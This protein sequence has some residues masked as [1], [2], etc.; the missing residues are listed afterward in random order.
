[1]GGLVPHR[2]MT[3]IPTSEEEGMPTHNPPCPSS[4]IITLLGA[5]AN[6]YFIDHLLV[7]SS[8]S[9]PNKNP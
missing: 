9:V 1:M 5:D 2:Q 6:G 4:W 8:P 3:R 7:A